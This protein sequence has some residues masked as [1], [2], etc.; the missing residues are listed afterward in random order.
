M[1]PITVLEVTETL[2]IVDN[3]DYDDLQINDLLDGVDKYF[4]DEQIIGPCG[5][6]LEIRASCVGNKRSPGSSIIHVA[7]FSVIEY[8][9]SI[10]PD[11]SLFF[12]NRNFQNNQ[13]AKLCLRY[14]NYT[15]VWKVRPRMIR[16]SARS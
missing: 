11:K 8:L 3:D 2:F 1:R 10:I 13:P 4:V 12:S 5:S 6:L 14:L 16:P 7:H 15:N 9:L